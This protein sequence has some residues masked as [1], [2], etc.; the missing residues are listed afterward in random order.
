MIGG[1]VTIGGNEEWS[2]SHES[3]ISVVIVADRLTA[4]G[5]SAYTVRLLDRLP[6]FGIQ[7]RLLCRSSDC[8]D[9]ERRRDLPIEESPHLEFPV[10]RWVVLRDIIKRSSGAPPR[11]VHVQTPAS[12]RVGERLAAAWKCPLVLSVHDF[13]PPQMNI[14][15]APPYGGKISAVSQPVKDDLLQRSRLKA[16]Q[17]AVIH[18]GVEEPPVQSAPLRE[19]TNPV[20]VVGTAGPLEPRKGQSFFL[21]AAKLVH[22]QRPEVEFLIAGSGPEERNLRRLTQELGLTGQVTFVPYLRK[23]HDAISAMDIFCLPSL[24]QGLGTLMLEAMVRSKPVIATNVGGV[25]RVIHDGETGLIIPSENAPQL[26][27]KILQLLGDPSQAQLLAEN[28]KR[29]V[30]DQFSVEQ[31]LSRTAS[32]Y[33]EVLGER[34]P[35]RLS[36]IS[37]E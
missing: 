5:S 28:G 29:L 36:P 9:P 23:Y 4:R 1:G 2:F 6:E 26:A 33:R 21:Q 17:I 8:I 7:P 34:P 30:L 32:L 14:R 19:R 20:M 31:M 25:S 15:F 13:L 12:L 3:D 35:L 22:A 16:E 10:W 24:Q 18:S 11:L 37:A 27:A